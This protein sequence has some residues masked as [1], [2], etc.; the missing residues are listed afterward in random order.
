MIEDRSKI[1]AKS[2]T[3]EDHLFIV[4]MKLKFGLLNRDISIRFG[5]KTQ[6]TS[7]IYRCYLPLLAKELIFFYCVAVRKIYLHVLQV[8]KTVVL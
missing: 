2:L 3:L 6:V 7:K 5:I 4:L 1:S 8:L